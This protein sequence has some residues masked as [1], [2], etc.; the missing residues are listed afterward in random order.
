MAFCQNVSTRDRPAWK[1]EEE[2]ESGGGD[3]HINLGDV[4]RT[5]LVRQTM[6]VRARPGDVAIREEKGP[7]VTCDTHN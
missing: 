7:L 4:L 3:E 6:Q 2:E 1:E 5:W